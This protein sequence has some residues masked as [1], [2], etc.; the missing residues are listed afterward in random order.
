MIRSTFLAIA[1]CCLVLVGCGPSAEQKKMVMDLNSEVTTMIN[2]AQASLGNLDDMAAQVTSAMSSADSMR[3]KLPE[4]S[5]S[6]RGAM[7]EL[8]SAKDRLM[9]VKEN[10]SAWLKNYKTPDLA[11]MKIDEVTASL[12][13]NKEE[14][15]TASTEISN[16]LNAAKTA[17]D[18]YKNVASMGKDKML[19]RKSR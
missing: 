15:S 19:L 17:I 11:N 14:L 1:L 12:K 9:G 4:D 13:K 16:A 3:M 7:N 18:G 8:N 2:S 5:T 6:L 10:V